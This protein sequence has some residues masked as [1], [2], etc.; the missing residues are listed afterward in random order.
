MIALLI[1]LGWFI[2]WTMMIYKFK[3]KED[4]WQTRLLALLLAPLVHLHILIWYG[5]K[6]YLGDWN[7]I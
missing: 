7:E 5:L 3:I 6:S 1:L 2:L 4:D